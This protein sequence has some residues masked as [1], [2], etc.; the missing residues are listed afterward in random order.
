MIVLKCSQTCK[1]N[2][3]KALA[4]PPCTPLCGTAAP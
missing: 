1:T 4:L 2:A 3:A